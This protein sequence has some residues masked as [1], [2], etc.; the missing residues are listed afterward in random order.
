MIKSGELEKIL[1]R[2]VMLIPS[3]FLFKM[4][5]VWNTVC[6]HACM[7]VCGSIIVLCDCTHRYLHCF[8]I[9]WKLP[10]SSPNLAKAVTENILWIYLN[11][12]SHWAA[13]LKKSSGALRWSSNS[14]VI[15]ITES[16]FYWSFFDIL[17]N[18]RKVDT[19]KNKSAIFF[20]LDLGNGR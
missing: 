12:G 15:T 18:C 13:G 3:L 11:L 20:L 16:G 5:P 2:G 7:H 9:P 1:T 14:S 4:Q 17:K 19:F 8:P 10:I 6:I